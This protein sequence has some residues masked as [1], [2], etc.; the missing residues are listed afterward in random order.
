MRSAHGAVVATTAALVAVAGAFVAFTLRA[1]S[2]QKPPDVAV[3]SRVVVNGHGLFITCQGSG[4]P[5][6]ILDAGL[7]DG[8]RAWDRVLGGEEQRDV[9]VCEYD[10]WGVGDSEPYTGDGARDIGDA[11]GDLHALLG[12][13]G[14]RPP[15]VLVSHSIAG[16]IARQYVQQYPVEVK[17]LVMVDTAPDDWDLRNGRAVFTSGG[18]SL[19]IAEVAAALRASDD[20]GDRPVVVVKAARTSEISTA[21]EF[22]SYW[23]AAQQRLAGLSTNSMYVVAAS[24]NHGVPASQPAVVNG[25]IDLVLHSV[26]TGERLPGCGASSLPPLG[27]TC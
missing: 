21:P 8:R 9:R 6:V 19:D 18:E 10:R 16:L 14:V 24:S 1:D 26:R 3:S 2:T 20:L 7:G 25:A 12:A 11:T 27:A 22:A 4:S 15:Y 17:G 5:A 23:Q 13:A